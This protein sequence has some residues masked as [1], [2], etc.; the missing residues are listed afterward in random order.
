MTELRQW[1]EDVI[2]S[3]YG[4]VASRLAEALDMSVS[5]FQR[6]TKAGTLSI[7]NLLRLAEE[8][9]ESAT[10]LLRLAGKGDLADQIE[11]LY[12]AQSAKPL[13]RRAAALARAYDGADDK[14]KRFLD[15]M[16]NRVAGD[17]EAS[18]PDPAQTADPK[19]E[20]RRSRGKTNNR[21][22]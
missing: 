21:R 15:D 10:H 19:A 17:P 4:G 9:G 13:S 22:G 14:T 12:G 5:A 2:E 1:V 18:E 7:G 6:S 8:T 3:R 20:A 11:R 16:W